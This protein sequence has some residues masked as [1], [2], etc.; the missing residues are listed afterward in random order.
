MRNWSNK[1]FQAFFK[2]RYKLIERYIEHPRET[3]EEV[4]FRLLKSAKHTEYGQLYGF[5]DIHS[6]A[7]Y[8]AQ[9]PIGD[10]PHF[11]PY[12]KRMMYGEKDV[13]WDGLVAHFAK[14]SGTTTGKSKFIPLPRRNIK[15]AHLRSS[16]EALTLLY[17]NRPEAKIFGTKNMLIGGSL[18][19]FDQYPR[20]EYGDVSAFLIRS[21]PN[22]ARPFFALDFETALLSEW[23]EKLEKIAQAGIKESNVSMMGGVPTWTIVL[24]KRMLE[25]SGKS[26]MLEIWPNFQVFMHGGVSFKPYRSQF[27]DFFPSDQ[28]S[29]QEIYNASEGYFA[30]QSDFSDEGLL[31]FLNNGIYF[32]F[33]PMDQWGSPDAQ[34][35]PVWEVEK[36]VN[37]AMIIT[38]NA[39][40][41]R[42]QLGDTVSFTSTYPYKIKITGRTK[43]FV[44]AFGEEVM[45]ENTD[46]ALAVTC[47][48]MDA[49][50]S[51]Y[52]VAP[53]YFGKGQEN[54]GHEWLIEF[55]RAPADLEA[56]QQLLDQELQKV[57]SDYE[58]K[59]YKNIALQNLIIRSLPKGSFHDWLRS[60]G[61]FGGQ[62]K[63]PRLANHRQY[64][65]EILHFLGER[66]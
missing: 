40:L 16:W 53:F 8:A 58:A 55:K 3:Q 39:G 10:Y 37:Y 26:N 22:V 12:I 51:E 47:R 42:Y 14:S 56:F 9:V 34:A 32:E 23:E 35:I 49:Q 60:K 61:K 5:A 30:A 59:R 25:L 7:A 4:L 62:N 20:T 52:T 44:N 41:W 27:E 45:V 64:V 6:P 31:L 19:Q 66:V 48:Q 54:G 28:V 50:V 24:F 36:G 38:T 63:V 21:M 43:Q 11:Y 57:N 46:Q 29:F 18:E 33:I 13:L 15:L 2:Q 17:H 1:V 65:E